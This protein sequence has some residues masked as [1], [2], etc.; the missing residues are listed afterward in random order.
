[1][2]TAMRGNRIAVVDDGRIV[3]LGSHDE[4]VAKNGKYAEMYATYLDHM[5]GRQAAAG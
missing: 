1:L 5:N 2:A 4:L 3:E